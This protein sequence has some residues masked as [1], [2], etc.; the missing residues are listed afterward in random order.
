MGFI[1]LEGFAPKSIAVVGGGISGL[2]CAWLLSRGHR[3]TLYEA[4]GRLGGHSHTVE[5]T[6]GSKTIAVDT[7]FIAYNEKTYPNLAAL[8]AHLEVP[9][10]ATEM[11]F[12][13][14]VD[15]GAFEYAGSDL[16]GLLAQPT[17]LIR[18][19]FWRM[20]VDLLRF[21]RN[22]S[23]DLSQMGAMTLQDY[24]DANGYG[25]EFRRDHL[26]PMAAAIWSTP[27]KD[28]GAHPAAAFVRF[29]ETHGL[30]QLSGRPIWRT[31][32]GGS[33]V[34][35]DR[36]IEP[37]KRNIRVGTPVVAIHRTDDDVEIVDAR[38]G[39]ARYDDVVIAA[40]ADRALA[41]LS[42]ASDEERRL[43]G[44]FRYE[45]NEAVLH[46]DPELMPRRRAAWSSWNYLAEGPEAERRLSVTYWMN[47]LQSLGDAPPLFVTLNPP[48]EP[49]EGAVLSRET[50]DHPQF[51]LAAVQAQRHLWSLQGQRRTWYCGAYFGAGFHEDGLQA[52]LAVAEDLGGIKRPWRVAEENGRIERSPGL[53]AIREAVVQ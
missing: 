8:F 37:F 53:P 43:L 20:L 21:Y 41:M 45:R 49:R 46:L 2:S 29:C 23:R 3:V 36:L 32:V 28:V 34:Y 50:Y 19:R 9:T 6:I 31:V 33:Q 1:K 40:H 12:S 18:P 15:R 30:L 4:D 13:A 52:G 51:D 7:G 26:F 38:G 24:L 22:A 27:A 42:D 16:R 44:A 39:R 17:N 5:A 48:R 35:V 47:R 11:S 25:A 14:S 10:I